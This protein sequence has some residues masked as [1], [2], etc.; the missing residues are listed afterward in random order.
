MTNIFRSTFSKFTHWA[1]RSW[2]MPFMRVFPECLATLVVVFTSSH[3]SQRHTALSLEFWTCWQYLC[4]ASSREMIHLFRVVEVDLIPTL[5]LLPNRKHLRQMSGNH[6]SD[7]VLTN[8]LLKTHWHTV[9]H[10]VANTQEF[11][12]TVIKHSHIFLQYFCIFDS[13]DLPTFTVQWDTTLGCAGV[14]GLRWKQRK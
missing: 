9:D 3:Q 1:K 12:G 7:P 11:N 13:T 2:Q 8:M 5:E 4:D 14:S 6:P 10:L